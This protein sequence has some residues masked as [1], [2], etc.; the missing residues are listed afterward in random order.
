METEILSR[1]GISADLITSGVY[2]NSKGEIVFT[3][4]YNK[5]SS[6]GRYNSFS[7]MVDNMYYQPSFFKNSYELGLGVEESDVIFVDS[8]SYFFDRIPSGIKNV[9]YK[10]G[11]N[12]IIRLN[13]TSNKNGVVE[14]KHDQVIVLSFISENSLEFKDTFNVEIHKEFGHKFH[15]AYN[16]IQYQNDNSIMS[17]LLI[18]AIFDTYDIDFTAGTLIGGDSSKYYIGNRVKV[19][20][21]PILYDKIVNLIIDS[22]YYLVVKESNINMV[23]S[24]L[25]NSNKDFPNVI[26]S[27]NSSLFPTICRDLKSKNNL[28]D[29]L[30][31]NSIVLNNN[32]IIC[33]LNSNFCNG[34]YKVLFS[35]SG[36]ICLINI[37]EDEVPNIYPVYSNEENVQDNDSYINTKYDIPEKSYV[38]Y[39]SSQGVLFEYSNPIEKDENKYYYITSPMISSGIKDGLSKGGSFTPDS[40]VDKLVTLDVEDNNKEN[41]IGTKISTTNKDSKFLTYMNISLSLPTLDDDESKWKY[42][43][44]GELIIDNN[45]IVKDYPKL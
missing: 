45:Q 5:P 13:F 34:Y 25:N 26:I 12:D 23:E 16:G 31:S 29:E 28:P 9:V 2:Y 42:T 19:T 14:Y 7:S 1:S 18:A 10:N 41:V 15:R 44:Y 32:D 27:E 22:D 43:K 39:P 20:S 38:Y 35:D 33:I 21:T 30:K 36:E 8:G 37:T 6:S 40:L 24:E 11:N 3:R 4:Q 17:K